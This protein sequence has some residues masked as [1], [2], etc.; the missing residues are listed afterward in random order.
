MRALEVVD[1]CQDGSRRGDGVQ[2]LRDHAADLAPR[3]LRHVDVDYDI[4]GL[5]EAVDVG[6][7]NP[8][9]RPA[10]EFGD[11][12]GRVGPDWHDA[13]VVVR[14]DQPLAHHVLP[15]GLVDGLGC[16]ARLGDGVEE[17]GGRISNVEVLSLYNVPPTEVVTLLNLSETTTEYI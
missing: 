17:S 13:P 4:L 11:S 1:D 2:G 7:A 9:E 12:V 5:E 15:C 10:A 6:I 16:E 8:F 3:A 14:R